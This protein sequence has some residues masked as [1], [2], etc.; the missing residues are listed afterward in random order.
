MT[1]ASE[2]EAWLTQHAAAMM[3]LI[4]Q[5]IHHPGDAE[6]V[7]QEAFLRF[8]QSRAKAIDP[9]AYLYGCARRCAHDWQRQRRRRTRREE[10][11]GRDES[12]ASSAFEA[13]EHDERRRIIEAALRTLDV[14]QREVVVM[15]IWADLTFRQIGVVLGIPTDTAASRYRYALRKLATQLAPEPKI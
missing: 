5:R 15:K 4:R 1:D 11:A 9:V 8:W 12:I 10:R 7:V 2:R 6:D 14:E 3:L 13:I